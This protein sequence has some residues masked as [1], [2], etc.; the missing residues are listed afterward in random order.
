MTAITQSYRAVS[1]LLLISVDRLI[2]IGLVAL[3][4]ALAGWITA[5]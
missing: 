3:A 4:L 5:G 2:S 1:L